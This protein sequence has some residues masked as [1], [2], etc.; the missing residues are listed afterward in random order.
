MQYVI[1]P[2]PARTGLDA[3]NN[4]FLP[5]I[6]DEVQLTAQPDGARRDVILT[7]I[8][9]DNLGRPELNIAHDG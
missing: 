6:A 8:V 2:L 7:N 5:T 4:G 3:H 1:V 9:A